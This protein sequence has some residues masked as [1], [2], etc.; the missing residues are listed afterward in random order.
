M[1][2]DRGYVTDGFTRTTEYPIL[3]AHMPGH[4]VRVVFGVPDS[5]GD[6]RRVVG[7]HGDAADQL[8]VVIN[9]KT[10]AKKYSVFR[11]QFFALEE[12]AF[13]VTKHV[14]VP[15]YAVEDPQQHPERKV[16]PRMLT[17]DPQARHWGWR[18][19]TVVKVTYSDG[20]SMFRLVVDP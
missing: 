4:S 18:P 8:I 6:V 15:K 12:V 11:A 9:A 16:Y 13:D 2:V 1:M 20:T 7:T 3:D 14:D 5:L 19:G 10:V 17:T